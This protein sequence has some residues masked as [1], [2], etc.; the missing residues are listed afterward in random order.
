MPWRPFISGLLL[1]WVLVISA[2]SPGGGEVEIEGQV[3]VTV[4][5]GDSVPLSL[6]PVEV[7]DRDSIARFLEERD[8]EIEERRGALEE[9][10]AEREAELA[11]ALREQERRAES[12]AGRRESI[13]VER[14]AFLAGLSEEL[15]EYRNKI[16]ANESFIIDLDATPQPP[17]GVPGREE[18]EAYRERL[19]RWYSMRR[20]EREAWQEVLKRQN[21]ELENAIDEARERRKT[22]LAAWDEELANLEDALNEAAAAVSD[23]EEALKQAKE[24]QRRYPSMG[25][26]FAG[27][28]N[29]EFKVRTDANG[30]FLLVLR[31][32]R[33]VA[34]VARVNREIRGEA[35]EHAWLL[36]L[37]PGRRQP[38]KV[39]MSNHNSISFQRGREALAAGA[40]AEQHP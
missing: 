28:P 26:Y 9:A 30:D 3:F 40:N 15:D 16:L 32:N 10:V 31:A 20:S 7:Y 34:V 17:E 24:E 8:R 36:W 22:G 2:C 13:A 18:F 33:Q 19:E 35:E 29:P 1:S 12:L 38:G 4:P 23:A 14:E 21:E 25:E 39:L 37:D 5:D 11:A 27:L 6:V